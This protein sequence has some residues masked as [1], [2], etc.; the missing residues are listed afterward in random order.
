M[1][2]A[3]H[4]GSQHTCPPIEA[5]QTWPILMHGRHQGQR[6]EQG[7]PGKFTPT[8]FNSHVSYY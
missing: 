7:E 5:G 1:S 4:I 8:P 6:P 2:D 3:E